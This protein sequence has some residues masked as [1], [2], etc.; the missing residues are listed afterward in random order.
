MLTF[1]IILSGNFNIDY[2]EFIDDQ[3]EAASN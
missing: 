3:I 2:N 1:K